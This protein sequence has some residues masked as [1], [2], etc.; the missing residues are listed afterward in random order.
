[1]RSWT[2]NSIK[3]DSWELSVSLCYVRTQQEGSHMYAR[4]RVLNRTQ[5][6]LAPWSQISSFQKCEKINSCCLSY[7]V[8]GTSQ[9]EQTNTSTIGKMDLYAIAKKKENRSLNLNGVGCSSWIF[10]LCFYFLCLFY[11]V[12]DFGSSLKNQITINRKMA[13]S[14]KRGWRM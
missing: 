10:N 13:S 14:S 9:P 3:T 12:F 6:I 4:K 5:T 7:P 11:F 8:D 2:Q 1:M